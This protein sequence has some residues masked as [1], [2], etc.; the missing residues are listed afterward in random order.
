[1]LQRIKTNPA[2]SPRRVVT[3]KVRDKAVRRL[4]KGDG[5]ENR[6]DPDRR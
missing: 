1:M 6:D 5:D 4:M 2:Q 3:E